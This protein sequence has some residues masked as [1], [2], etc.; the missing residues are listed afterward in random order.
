MTHP[1][2]HRRASLPDVQRWLDAGVLRASESFRARNL[3]GAGPTLRSVWR[4]VL[5]RAVW[6]GFLLLAAALVFFIASQ[7]GKLELYGRLA[8]TLGVT[9]SATVA[10]IWLR[11]DTVGGQAAAMLAAL[12]FGPVMA[13]YGQ[14]FQTGESWDLFGRWFLVAAAYAWAARSMVC[15]LLAIFLG[16]LTF[17]LLWPHLPFATDPIPQYESWPGGLALAVGAVVVA[18]TFRHLGSS[19]WNVRVLTVLALGTTTAIGISSLVETSFSRAEGLDQVAALALGFGSALMT[20]YVFRYPRRRD[21]VLVTAG[22]LAL[23]CLL[24]SAWGHYLFEIW[25]FEAPG[26]LALGVGICALSGA[27]T[28]WFRRW[29]ASLP[30]EGNEAGQEAQS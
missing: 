4:F 12:S 8:L 7:W 29:H 23:G 24:S 16:W 2:L 19:S 10:A 14:T 15:R 18:W 17:V 3:L 6:I 9:A 30:V 26:F 1:T 21:A 28:W 27:F 22:L 5:M 11:T 25:D 20:L 13:V